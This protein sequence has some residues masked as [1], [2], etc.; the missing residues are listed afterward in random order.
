MR[1]LEIEYAVRV[2]LFSKLEFKAISLVLQGFK[3]H[4]ILLAE[5]GSG[6]NNIVFCLI[7]LR[8]ALCNGP[9][10]KSV[11]IYSFKAESLALIFTHF[12]AFQRIDDVN[13]NFLVD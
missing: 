5:H 2:Q 9:D 10:V 13:S 4:P 12:D 8:E 3:N 11:L 1:A 6:R 7:Y